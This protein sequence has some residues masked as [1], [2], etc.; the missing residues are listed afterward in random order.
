MK[1]TV[2][3]AKNNGGLAMWKGLGNDFENNKNMFRREV[4]RVKKG[5][6]AKDEMV[7]D[8]N[9]Q[10]MRECF[11][12]RGRRAEY[13]KQVLNVEDVRKENINVSSYWRMPVLGELNQRT[14]SIAVK[15]III[16]DCE[17]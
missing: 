5:V 4:M 8:V 17:L 14:I 12:V 3:V 16:N 7:K 9:G 10:I 15:L 2:K 11:E 13:F 1:Q 6:Q